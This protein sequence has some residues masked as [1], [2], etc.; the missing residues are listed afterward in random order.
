MI[1]RKPYVKKPMFH[2]ERGLDV[3]KKVHGYLIRRYEGSS[4]LRTEVRL[5][6]PGQCVAAL[7]AAKEAN[8]RLVV[9]ALG[10]AYGEECMEIVDEEFL[11]G[12][13]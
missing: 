3:L 2:S 9:Y 4:G 13:M 12:R 7:R 10:M 1:P 6:D 5:R 11:L 8:V